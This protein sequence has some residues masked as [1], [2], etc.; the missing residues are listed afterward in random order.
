MFSAIL[1]LLIMM[2][3]FALF[4]YLSPLMKD[5]SSRGFILVL[6]KAS[7]ISL[8]LL[9]FFFFSGEYLFD[10]ILDMAFSSFK[11]FGGIVIFSFAY[12]YIVSGRKA[13]IMI[14]ENLDDLASEI[15]LPFIAGVGSIS[16]AVLL[17]HKFSIIAGVSILTA[18]I[19]LNFLIIIGLKTMKDKVPNKKLKVAFDKNMQIL[20]RLM[21]FIIGAIGIDLIIKGIKESFF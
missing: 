6:F 7:T 1:T 14:K 12:L 21:G 9:L 5:L 4:I 8:I 2:N 15:A 19:V 17:K 3:P 18:V 20:M 16:L 11:I 10:E 13:I